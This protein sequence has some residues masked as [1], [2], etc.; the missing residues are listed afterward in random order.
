MFEFHVDCRAITM[1]NTDRVNI[2]VT[3]GNIATVV[4]V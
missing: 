1:N 4:G 3:V 2:V